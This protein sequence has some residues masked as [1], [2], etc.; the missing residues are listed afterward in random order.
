VT[1]ARRGDDAFPQMMWSSPCSR[2]R[3]VGATAA[4]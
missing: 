3:L 4:G 2:A 1:R